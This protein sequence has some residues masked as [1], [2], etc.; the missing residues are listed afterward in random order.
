MTTSKD[1]SFF[2][3]VGHTLMGMCKLSPT[4]RKAMLDVV[5]NAYCEKCRER[6]RTPHVC[7]TG[8]M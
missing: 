3:L 5:L 8:A 4:D 6:R 1:D 7:N 2:R